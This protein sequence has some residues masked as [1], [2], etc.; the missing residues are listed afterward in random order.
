MKETKQLK[1]AIEKK[2][3]KV[4]GWKDWEEYD[5][6]TKSSQLDKNVRS[7]LISICIEQTL[8]DVCEEINNKKSKIRV[9][10]NRAI[11]E[12]DKHLENHFLSLGLLCDE[13]LK[14]FQG[15]ENA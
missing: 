4:R 14:E 8:K 6:I 15:E 12:K 13:L 9:H 10:Y 7:E 1:K 11:K 2:F 3:L 5:K